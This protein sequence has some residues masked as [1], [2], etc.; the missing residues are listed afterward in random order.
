M[1]WVVG[2]WDGEGWRFAGTYAAN[3]AEADPGYVDSGHDGVRMIVSVVGGGRWD[4]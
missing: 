1:A 2:W 3:V 4:V